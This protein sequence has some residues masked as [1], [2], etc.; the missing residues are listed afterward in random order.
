MMNDLNVE[1]LIRELVGQV[2]GLRSTVEGIETRI[3]DTRQDAREARDATQTLTAKLA[4]QDTPAQLEKIRGEMAAGFVAARADL[5]N[6]A[7]RYNSELEKV[8]NRISS[9][10]ERLNK[11]VDETTSRIKTLENFHERNVGVSGFVDWL[12][13]HA[14]WIIAMGLAISSILG[15][16]A[17]IP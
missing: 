8:D 7:A 2:S 1:A 11:R 15:F 14:P 6:S 17:K 4:G 12:G 9:V 5:I 13:K 10:D 3:N 16:K